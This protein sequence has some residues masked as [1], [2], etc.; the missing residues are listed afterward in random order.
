MLHSIHRHGVLRLSDQRFLKKLPP[1][2][3]ISRASL[4]LFLFLFFSFLF[5]PILFLSRFSFLAANLSF[6][7]RSVPTNVSIFVLTHLHAYTLRIAHTCMYYTCTAY[8][9]RRVLHTNL[10]RFLLTATR[11]FPRLVPVNIF[12]CR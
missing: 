1:R 5:F 6:S 7:S 4:F 3:G 9:V 8:A 11:R 12:A 10:C 2:P